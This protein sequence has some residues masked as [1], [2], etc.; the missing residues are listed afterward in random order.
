MRVTKQ[1]IQRCILFMTLAVTVLSFQ[2]VRP[3]NFSAPYPTAQNPR[4]RSV[5]YVAASTRCRV[6]LHRELV[7]PMAMN[8]S[9]CAKAS[10]NACL[11]SLPGHHGGILTVRRDATHVL[12]ENRYLQ[13]LSVRVLRGEREGKAPQEKKKSR[14]APGHWCA[15]LYSC[16][17]R[18]TS[19]NFGFNSSSAA[20]NS[21]CDKLTKLFTSSV[22]AR[23]FVGTTVHDQHES[24]LVQRTQSQVR[25][26]H[27]GWPASSAPLGPSKKTRN[28]LLFLV[29]APFAVKS[30][31][32]RKQKLIQ[33][34]NGST[35]NECIDFLKHGFP[36]F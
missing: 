2:S 16:I 22:Y 18:V 27:T 3:S 29:W 12:A 10:I 20:V 4:S 24:L 21:L 6:Q 15:K 36:N 8:T 7:C 32:I 17:P 35:K 11:L 34:P 1:S 9:C 26:P 14:T 13:L 33:H 19:S 30:L 5:L 31:N 23:F 28:G 25:A